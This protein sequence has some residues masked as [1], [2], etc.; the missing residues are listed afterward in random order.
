M[1]K[2]VLE[3]KDREWTQKRSPLEKKGVLQTQA[4]IIKESPLGETPMIKAEKRGLLYKLGKE[5]K[6]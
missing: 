3:K 1:V 5:G 2:P 6:Q 4:R